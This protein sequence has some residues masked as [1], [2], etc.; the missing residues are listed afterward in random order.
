MATSEA[1][2]ASQQFLDDNQYTRNNILR[3]EK[4]F[5]ETFVS[6]GGLKTTQVRS[7]GHVV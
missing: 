5:G 7:P 6:T 3:Y 4:I 1:Q 2:S